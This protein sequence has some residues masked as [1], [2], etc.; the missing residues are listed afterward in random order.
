MWDFQLGKAIG[1]MGKTLPFIGL[2]MAIYFGITLAY[3]IATGGGGGAGYLIGGGNGTDDAYAS[4]WWGAIAGFGTVSAVLYFAREYLLYL[5]KAGHIAVLVHLIDGQP[6]PQGR[7]Q[8]HFAAATVK[9]R[10]VESS[11]LF[12]LDLLIKGILRAFNATVMSITSLL[13]IPALQTL[14][15]FATAVVNMSLTYVDE[16]I[17]AYNIRT[18]QDNPWA[19]ARDGTVLYAQNYRNLLQNALW[20]TLFVWLLTIG[21]FVLIFAPVAAFVSV[22]PGVGG[23]WTFAITAIAAW[24]VKAALIDPIAMTCLMQAYFK[25]VDGQQPRP[26]WVAKLEAASGKFRELG[27]KA[28]TFGLRPTKNVTGI[29]GAAV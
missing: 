6:I 2:R 28:L 17:L 24:S 26:E 1:L 3:A 9:D 4:A 27:Q 22:F 20:L 23:F 5:V 8:I 29:A 7:S 16:V 14:V 11:V 15:K 10:F 25:A 19:G 21:V 13:P 18:K 12:A